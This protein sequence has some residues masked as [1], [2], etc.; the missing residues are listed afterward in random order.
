VGAAERATLSG[1][2]RLRLPIVRR[3][4]LADVG[5]TGLVLL[6]QSGPF[7]LTRP[8]DAP[9][10][11]PA[12]AWL[13]V[14]CSAL[15]VLARRWQPALCLL[16]SA[17]SIGVYGQIEITPAQPIWFGAL[18]CMYTVAY[19]ASTAMRI[20]SIVVT[21]VGMLA[22]I[23]SINTAIRELAT[24]SAAY[25]LGAFARARKEAAV[26]GR[27]Q[28]AQLAAERERTRIARDLHDILG[29]AFSL[30]VVQA[31]AGAAV[32]RHDPR[33]AEQ[34][35]DAISAAGRTAMDQLRATVGSLREAPRSPQPGLSDLAELVRR[36]EQAGLAVRLTEHGR[37]RPLPAQVQL[38]VYRV[39]QEALTNV[40]KHAGASAVT[41]DL[42][43]RDESFEV[44]VVDDGQAGGS[45]GRGP[46]DGSGHGLAGIQERVTAAGGRV[47][48]GAV[49]S[50]G[51][52]V[53]A[54]F[55]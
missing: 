40:V 2:P 53:Q 16:L 11:W 6:A 46:A 44:S 18:V 15:P 51:F 10:G 45:A 21:G 39:A 19:Q 23:G 55:A 49:A 20:A 27:E 3:E 54:V 1:W 38:A 14:L 28:A 47:E 24:W 22:T 33:R 35:F 13:A 4:R 34:A 43:W 48:F 26:A 37:Q 52:R 5:L 29:H 32:A 25:A 50:G 9:G 36:V 17:V 42:T 8:D 31:E 41:I 12:A 7:L 30:M